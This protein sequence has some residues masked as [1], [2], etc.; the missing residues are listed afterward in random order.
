[1]STRSMG[2]INNKIGKLED[3]IIIFKRVIQ[4]CLTQNRF[5]EKIYI[6]FN[7]NDGVTQ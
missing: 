2:I 4:Y 1:M 3:R 5:T 6:L 7:M